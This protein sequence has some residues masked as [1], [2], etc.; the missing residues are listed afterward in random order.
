[1]TKLAIEEK[2]QQWQQQSKNFGYRNGYNKQEYRKKVPNNGDKD[3]VNKN[4]NPSK[5]STSKQGK[6][7]S[8][9]RRTLQ[10]KII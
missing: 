10:C 6:N 1:M 5:E 3:T 9:V 8:K 2:R 4:E 7:G